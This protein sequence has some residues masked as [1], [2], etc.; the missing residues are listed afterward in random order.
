MKKI[1]LLIYIFTGMIC[2]PVFAVFKD[3]TPDVDKAVSEFSGQGMFGPFIYRFGQD[4]FRPDG[5]LSRADVILLLQEYNALT[6]KLIAYD[7]EITV[8]LNKLAA[9]S[10]SRNMNNIL[11]EVQKNIDTMLEG[12]EVVKQLRVPDNENSDIRP[13]SA[14]SEKTPPNMLKI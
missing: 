4:L 8:K 3:V 9:D 6:N 2:G 13:V 5:T 12:S 14:V 11:K 7:K 10:Q 1:I